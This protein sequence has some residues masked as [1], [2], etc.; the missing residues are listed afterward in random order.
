MTKRTLLTLTAL[1][2]PLALFTACEEGGQATAAQV[3][4]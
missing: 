3:L 4:V 2:A 1:L